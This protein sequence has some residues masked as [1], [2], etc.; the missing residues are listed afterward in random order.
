MTMRRSAGRSE[1]R[2]ALMLAAVVWAGA[3]LAA[4]EPKLPDPKAFR[5]WM[6][7][8]DNVKGCAALSLPAEAADPIAYLRLERPAG[9][10]GA[11]RL[12]LRLRGEWKSPPRALQL[13]LDGAPFPAAGKALPVTVEDDLATLAFSPEDTAA[14]IEAARKATS[15]SVAAAGIKASV[16]LAGSVASMLW[17]DEQQGRLGTPSALIRKGNGAAVPPAPEAPLVVARPA[18]PILDMKLGKVQ[19]ARLR[20]DLKK[21]KPDACEDDAA[22]GDEAWALGEKRML[23]ALACSRGAYNVSSSFFLMPENEPAKAKP[24][25]FPDGD[26]DDGNELTNAS[27]DPRTGHLSFFA[28]GRGI[29]DCGVSGGYAWTGTSFAR[30]ELSMMGEC[31]GIG[32]DDWFTLYRSRAK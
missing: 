19:A 20:A 15:L 16:S 26:G 2:T 28:K 24:M 23:V 25:R 4:G 8:C 3:A 18:P 27:F 10:T 31:R 21:R 1:A 13:Q 11:A 12:V 9:P 32:P 14:L 30:T 5:D 22:E 7:A 17:I 29:G 6:A